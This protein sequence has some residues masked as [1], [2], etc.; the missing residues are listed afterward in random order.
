MLSSSS[1]VI[2][3]FCKQLSDRCLSCSSKEYVRS[4]GKSLACNILYRICIPSI[5][6]SLINFLPSYILR[7]C[8]FD[9]ITLGYKTIGGCTFWFTSALIVAEMILLLLLLTRKKSI[10]FYFFS[11]AIV[12][13]IGRYVVAN[14]LVLFASYPSFP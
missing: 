5:L 12:F 9:L 14:N 11:C 8:S 6:F 3:F 7:G 13:S 1:L 2:C 4:E 10:W